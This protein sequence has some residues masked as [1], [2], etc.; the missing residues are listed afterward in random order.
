MAGVPNS[1]AHASPGRLSSV[2]YRSA[3]LSCFNTSSNF[4]EIALTSFQRGR[5]RMAVS[6]ATLAAVATV[7]PFQVAAQIRLDR[8]TRLIV[9]FPPGGG[10]DAA[11]RLIGSK[12]SEISGM[13]VV[14]ENRVG[15]SGTIGIGAAAKMPAD[16]LHLVI[17]QADNLAV[18]PLLIPSVPYDPVKD[19]QAVAHVAD[20]PIVIVT[21][22]SQPFQTLADVVRAGK[23]DPQLLTF[24]SAGVG[25]T[26]HLSGELFAQAAGFNMR[27]IAYKGSA[28][29][30]TDVLASRIHLM[31]SSI[32][33]VV[34]H[35]KSGKLR[36]LAVTSTQRSVALPDVPTVAEAAGLRGFDVGTWYGIF[37]PA[38]TPPDAV[39]RLNTDINKVLALPEVKAFLENQEGGLIRRATPAALGEQLRADIP[40]WQGVIKDAKVVLE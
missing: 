33:L 26:P 32:S 12:L 23:A 9:P 17:G 36:A 11:A 34:P 16:G 7:S 38:G 2:L 5:R 4:K 22:G 24:G 21:A 15:A 28:P 18:A 8:Q 3:L 37:A 29:A 19:L 13:P 40:R 20:I 25:T 1:D 14:I 27:H 35:I 30:L 10:T 31:M 39:S 6:L